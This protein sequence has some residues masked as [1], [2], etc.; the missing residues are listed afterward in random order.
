MVQ[1]LGRARMLVKLDLAYR[2]ILVHPQDRQVLG[3]NWEHQTYLEAALPFGLRSAPK[4]SQPWPTLS[5][6]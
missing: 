1:C 2:S 5:C 6:G 3:V 4:Y